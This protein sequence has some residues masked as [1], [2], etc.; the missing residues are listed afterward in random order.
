MSDPLERISLDK[1]LG[2]PLVVIRE[3]L[4]RYTLA[5]Q[6]VKDKDVLDVACGTG[7]G[8]YLISY[9]AKSVSGYDKDEKAIKEV[10][11]DFQMKCPAFLEVRNLETITSLGN[12]LAQKFDVITCFE[13]LEH[14]RNPEKLLNLIKNHL[15][16]KGTFYFST[17][18][19][20][21]LKDNSKWHKSIFNKETLIKLMEQYFQKVK[22]GELWGQDQ[23]GLSKDLKKPY[24]VGKIQL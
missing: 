24:L 19:K 16:P 21:D 17:P 12:V 9:W 4:I 14:L 8:V 20:Q 6:N 10:K 5:L 13:T 1:N 3:H 18:N 7:Y 15:K 22:S 23:W 11:K 2:H